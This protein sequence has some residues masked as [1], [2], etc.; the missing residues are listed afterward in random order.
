MGH[1]LM[2]AKDYFN[3]ILYVLDFFH[4]KGIYFHI[5]ICE[6]VPTIEII[7]DTVESL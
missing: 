3:G 7:Y 6:Y 4:R 2:T 1:H 5:L